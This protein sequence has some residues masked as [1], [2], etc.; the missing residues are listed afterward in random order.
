MREEIYSFNTEEF[1]ALDV[2]AMALEDLSEL[3]YFI[4]CWHEDNPVLLEWRAKILL[5]LLER[6]CPIAPLPSEEDELE[7][8]DDIVL[9]IE[10]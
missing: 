8:I 1:L 3:S 4:W 7:E 9:D 2:T 6:L 5:P 10:G